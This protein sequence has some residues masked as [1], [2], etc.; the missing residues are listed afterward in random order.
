MLAVLFVLAMMQAVLAV[1]QAKHLVDSST[2]RDT[3]LA[4][5]QQGDGNQ[6]KYASPEMKAD[7]EIVIMAVH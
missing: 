2:P 6:L 7:K 4:V 5:M 1:R 3:V